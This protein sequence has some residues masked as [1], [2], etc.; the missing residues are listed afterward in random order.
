MALFK[1][2]ALDSRNQSRDGV[3]EGAD[4]EAVAKLLMQQGLR[5]LEILSFQQGKKKALPLLA[6]FS[7]DK[8]TRSDLDFFTTQLALLLNSGLSLDAALRTLRQ[9]SHKPAFKQFT[10][11]LEKKLKEGK[12]FSQAL[13]EYPNFSPMYVN[14]VRAGEE[15][16]ALPAMLGKIADYQAT[17]QEL[18]QFIVSSSIYP[19][20]L[21]VVGF[22][23]IL[24]L[25]TVIL[26]RFEVLFAGMGHELPLHVRIMMDTAKAISNHPLITMV[27]LAAPPAAA[28]CYL[29]TPDG[30]AWY[31]RI[32]LRLP[33]IA[34]FV[35]TLE[36][37]RIFRTLEV[38]VKNGVHFATALKIASGVATNQEFRRLLHRATETLKE[39]RQISQR[40]KGE[41]L[42]PE[43]ATDL[44]AIGEE[45]G[46]V[47]QMCGQVADHYEKE[48][49]VRVKRLISLIEPVFIL[50]IALVA[51][52]VVI[53]MLSVILSINEIAG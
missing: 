45:S 43:L 18:R 1:Y 14:I 47:G 44:L 32:S 48:L 39:G 19:V 4:K 2:T 20:F 9:H 13:A 53:S 46:R 42:L 6:R 51:G 27:V 23:S 35:Q 50:L 33:L 24:I 29:K 8:L 21:L 25:L 36:T 41:G 38:L 34:G 52:Y 37:T 15:G 49:R 40:L 10:G 12:S 31:D 5:P 7:H 3:L 28:T 22:I 11:E 30:R 26:P 16:G 17:F